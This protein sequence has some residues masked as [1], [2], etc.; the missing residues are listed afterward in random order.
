MSEITEREYLEAV[1][2][3]CD[4]ALS[5]KCRNCK[6]VSACVRYIQQLQAELAKSKERCILA[7]SQNYCTIC[8]NTLDGYVPPSS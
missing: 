7:Q 8:G 5:D 3:R 6:A 2:G 4:Y 1:A